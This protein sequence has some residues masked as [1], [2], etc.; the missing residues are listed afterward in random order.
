MKPDPLLLAVLF[1]AAHRS[2]FAQ[3]ASETM[4]RD[5]Q[6]ARAAAGSGSWLVSETTSP[7]DYSPIVAATTLSRS[8]SDDAAMQLSISCRA[9]RTEIVVAGPTVSRKVST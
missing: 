6:S 7:L 9:G 2:A 8:G 5:A 4:S 1:I 3:G